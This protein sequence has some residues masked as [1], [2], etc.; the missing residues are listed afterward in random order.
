M[1]IILIPFFDIQI[2]FSHRSELYGVNV[3]GLKV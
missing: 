2:V 3:M 1:N